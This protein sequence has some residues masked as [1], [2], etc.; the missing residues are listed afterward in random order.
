MRQEEHTP[1]S[2]GALASFGEEVTDYFSRL[3][4]VDKLRE[5]RAMAGFTRVFPST[6]KPAHELRELL[7]KATPDKAWLPAYVVHGEGLYFEL[8]AERLAE[9]ESQQHVKARVAPLIE[10]FREVQAKRKL[11]AREISPR[12]VLLHSLA[13]LLINQLTFDCGYSS[14][15]LRERLY[16]SVDPQMPMAGVLIYA[17]T[18]IPKAQWWFS[19]HG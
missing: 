16:A 15:S 8:A 1:Y 18:A 19:A 9:W 7:V 12:F 6:D 2:R 3:L 4:L 14:A 11:D 10:R 17:P 5:T 13:H